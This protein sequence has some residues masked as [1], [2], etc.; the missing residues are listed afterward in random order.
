MKNPIKGIK[1]KIKVTDA[2]SNGFIIPIILY[3]TNII[4]ANDNATFAWPIIYADNT[5]S[6]S[7]TMLLALSLYF[8][9]NSFIMMLL[10]F[11]HL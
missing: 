2:K 7:A 1:A 9:G 8:L 6:P 4:M 10:F 5:S 3:P 11:L